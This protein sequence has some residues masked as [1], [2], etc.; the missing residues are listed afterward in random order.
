METLRKQVLLYGESGACGDL[1]MES[2]ERNA[3]DH[4]V[5]EP[6]TSIT[7]GCTEMFTLICCP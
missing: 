3:L 1:R 2:M 5:M 6:A 7:V 4:S